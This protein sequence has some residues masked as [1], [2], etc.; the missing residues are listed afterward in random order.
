[1]PISSAKPTHTARPTSI[2]TMSVGIRSPDLDGDVGEKEQTE[3][4]SHDH[5]VVEVLVGH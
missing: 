2:A 4:E 5:E 1:M 3:A